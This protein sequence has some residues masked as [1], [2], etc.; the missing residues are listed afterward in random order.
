MKDFYDILKVSPDS[1]LEDIK[2]SYRNLSKK[3]HPDINKEPNAE[4]IFKEINE[5]YDTLSDVEK[6]SIYDNRRHTK[7]IRFDFTDGF[8]RKNKNMYDDMFGSWYKHNQYT[9]FRR[10]PKPKGENIKVQLELSLD[11]YYRGKKLRLQYKRNIK[12]KHCK[13]DSKNYDFVPKKCDVCVGSGFLNHNNCYICNGVGYVKIPS[14]TYCKSTRLET[15]T[16]T[17]DFNIKQYFDPYKKIVL[18]G[19]GHEHKDKDSENGD[20]YIEIINISPSELGFYVDGGSIFKAADVTLVDCLLGT[21]LNVIFPDGE[22]REIE[23][24]AGTRHLEN[25][26]IEGTGFNI[27]GRRYASFLKINQMYPLDINDSQKELLLKFKE[28]EDSK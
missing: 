24:K 14:C 5:A 8:F 25:I 12:C 9:E 26:T 17:V 4:E 27:D 21:T 23:I 2:K 6:K 19:I 20:V 28:I 16:E 1:S 7:N 18:K 22:E 13:D 15:V 3:Y 11:D 10:K